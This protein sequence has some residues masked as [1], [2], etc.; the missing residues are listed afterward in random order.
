MDPSSRDSSKDRGRDTDRHSTEVAALAQELHLRK[1]Q[2]RVDCKRHGHTR[3]AALNETPE[4]LASWRWSAEL[5]AGTSKL[6][7]E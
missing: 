2:D 5:P 4:A 7:P 3:S 1:D 6:A